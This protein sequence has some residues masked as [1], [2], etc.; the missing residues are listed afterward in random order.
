[1][2][3]AVW[4]AFGAVVMR[5]SGGGRRFDSRP[6]TMISHAL[7]RTSNFNHLLRVPAARTP[8]R[9]SL[10]LKILCGVV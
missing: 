2:T 8:K 5:G 7:K 6:F 4:A 9:V 1:M 10:R 3:L